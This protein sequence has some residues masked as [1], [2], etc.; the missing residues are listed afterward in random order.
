MTEPWIG[1]A[2]VMTIFGIL[3]AIFSVIG[4]LLH[5]EVLRKGLHISLGLTA[6]SFPWLF[7]T[8]WPVLVVGVI[9]IMGFLGVRLG[10]PLLRPLAHKLAG[11]TRV[12]IGEYCFIIAT[13]VVFIFAA[14]DPVLYSIPILVL[15]LADAAA[16]LVGTR[17]GHHWYRTWDD[18][19]S[20]EGSTAFFIVAFA[21]IFLPLVLFTHAS[22]NLS[23]SVAGLVALA[24]TVLEASMGRGFDNLL[25][26]LGAL[27]AIK[28]T[29]LTRDQPAALEIGS[30]IVAAAL[31]LLIA[32][33]IV[34]LGALV[35]WMRSNAAARGAVR[36]SSS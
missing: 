34:L 27:A 11:I 10:L 5:P 33:L 30:P 35:S 3:F 20:I 6:L 25:V 22:V 4:D 26:P 21:C 28:A 16:A 32:L 13:C 2:L 7:E 8:V 12:S 17:Y 36:N 1:L 18:Y 31:S 9:S 14:D 23:A 29:G 24:T 15:S 19:K